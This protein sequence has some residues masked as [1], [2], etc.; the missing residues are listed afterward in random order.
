MQPKPSP[1]LPKP[2]QSSILG[3]PRHTQPGLQVMQQSSAAKQ[4]LHLSQIEPPSW[5]LP[6]STELQAQQ[7]Q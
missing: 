2:P 7:Q 3:S 1:Q 5:Q 4:P 6:D